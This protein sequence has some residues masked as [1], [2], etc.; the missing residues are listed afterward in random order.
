MRIQKNVMSVFSG[1][2][3]FLFLFLFSC[4]DNNGSETIDKTYDPNKPIELTTF[5]P[6]SGKYLEKVLLTGKNFGTDPEQ[7]R[8]YFN[9][10]RA[11]VVG[12][13]GDSILLPICQTTRSR[14]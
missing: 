10:K 7:I 11:A 4:K 13:T 12:S 5:Y 8:V 14:F 1:C 2:F 6:D 9:S 3:L